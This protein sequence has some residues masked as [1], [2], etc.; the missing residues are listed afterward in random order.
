MQHTSIYLCLKF[1]CWKSIWS[2]DN[3][4]RPMSKQ[5]SVNPWLY[6]PSGKFMERLHV[7]EVPVGHWSHVKGDELNEQCM[8]IHEWLKVRL[9][10]ATHGTT[11]ICPALEIM[12]WTVNFCHTVFL[13]LKVWSLWIFIICHREI[14]LQ[15]NSSQ[16]IF[17]VLYNV[18][19]II[20]KLIWTSVD[21]RNGCILFSFFQPLRSWMSWVR[22][23]WSSAYEWTFAKYMALHK[24]DCIILLHW[25]RN[26]SLPYWT[27]SD[28]IFC[29]MSEP[30]LSNS[31]L[32]Y[33]QFAK[34]NWVPFP[35]VPSSELE[36][37]D[38]KW[39]WTIVISVMLG[40]QPQEGSKTELAAFLHQRLSFQS[41]V[42]MCPSSNLF[43][44]HGSGFEFEVHYLA[45]PV[46]KP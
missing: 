34:Q 39:R 26:F 23:G 33:S 45:R 7:H 21:L 44:G 25:M 43:T 1:L 30:I 38:G 28:Y 41:G 22:K 6:L 5:N 16:V 4:V 36:W 32:E 37:I 20:C 11:H 15:F 10:T 19:I 2:C 35:Q 27:T 12:D 14:L 31:I 46:G 17:W 3:E 24:I 40:R 9:G 42:E 29:I 18:R 13:K 8:K